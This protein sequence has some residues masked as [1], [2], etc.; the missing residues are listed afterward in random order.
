MLTKDARRLAARADRASPSPAAAPAVA[1]LFGRAH[2]GRRADGGDAADRARHRLSASSG[3]AASPRARSATVRPATAAPP[4]GDANLRVRGLTRAGLVLS[5][6][7]VDIGLDRQARRASTRR[8]ARSRSATGKT[9]GRAQARMSPIGTSGNL[10]ERLSR[11]PMLAPAPLQ[12]PGRHPVAAD[13]A[14][15]A[16]PQR[17]GRGRRRRARHAQRSRASAARSAPSGARLE[18]AVTGTVIENIKS[19][20]R[21]GGS[22][23]HDRQLHAAPPRRAARSRAGARS[24]S[25]ARAASAWISTS[26]AQAAQ[27]IDRDD[28]KA[29]VTGAARRSSRTAAAARSRATS[30]WCQG[31]FQ[32]GSATAAAQV[33]RLNVREINRPADDVRAGARGSRPGGS[34]CASAPTTG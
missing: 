7:P 4:T 14:R 1:G 9:I 12:R 31:S 23:L 29:Q 26:H 15:A 33:P 24:I 18:S 17:P 6:R 10:V 5:S 8:C 21:F 3:S 2:R 34:T 11:A 27:L 22:R 16:R 13:R 28:I 30:N 19:S 20:G 25:S 32:L